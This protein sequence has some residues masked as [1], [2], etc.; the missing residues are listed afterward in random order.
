MSN[1]VREGIPA[2]GFSDRVN[3]PEIVAAVKKNRRTTTIL[4]FCI[5]PLPLIGFALYSAITDKMEMK[6][7][8]FV[9]LCVSGV[10]LLF[11]LWALFKNRTEK[12]YEAVVIDKTSKLVKHH[13]D[14]DDEDWITEYT[15]VAKT[16]DGKKKKI[17][18]RQGS[19]IW[20][21]KYLEEGD[22]FMYHPEF[23]FPYEKYDKSTAPYIACVSCVTHNPVTADRCSKCGLPLLK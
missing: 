13:S 12:S 4:S 9:G 21:Y 7:A 8:L 17:V 5:V 22:R 2:P 1:D 15:T 23:S 10:F 6:E 3:H 18:E 19:Q 14:S 11:A 20:A 16:T